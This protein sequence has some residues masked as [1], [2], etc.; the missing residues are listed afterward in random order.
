MAR[1]LKQHGVGQLEEMFAR[2]KADV[3]VLRKLDNELQYRQVPRA[4]ALLAE[5]H[6]AIHGGVVCPSGRHAHSG[7]DGQA[8]STAET[9]FLILAGPNSRG[10]G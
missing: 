6:A 1:P 5:V 10:V 8:T 2:G 4:V 3:T 9:G 7:R